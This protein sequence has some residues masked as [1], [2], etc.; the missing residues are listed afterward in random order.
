MKKD[1]TSQ[2]KDLTKR[3]E[4][5]EGSVGVPTEESPESQEVIA[6]P[7]PEGDNS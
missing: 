3:V 6:N 1:L 5:L 4:E 2:V 7:Q